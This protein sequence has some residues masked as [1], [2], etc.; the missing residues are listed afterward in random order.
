MF[1]F[2]F[3]PGRQDDKGVYAKLLSELAKHVS[4]IQA[5]SNAD[6]FMVTVDDDPSIID[7]T[8]A[9]VSRISEPAY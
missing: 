3:G 1:E 4:V 6:Y 9:A 5:W 8:K 7:L 2:F